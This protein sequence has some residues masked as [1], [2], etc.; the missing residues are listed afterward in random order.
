MTLILLW[1]S[2]IF[3][4]LLGYF[5]RDI[6]VNLQSGKRMKISARRWFAAAPLVRLMSIVCVGLL[7]VTILSTVSW[8]KAG[9]AAEKAETANAIT[10]R[11][12]AASAQATC[13]ALTLWQS[14]RIQTT[15]PD[16]SALP[17]AQRKRTRVFLGSLDDYIAALNHLQDA[18]RVE[19]STKGD[20]Q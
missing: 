15:P 12:E 19:C 10:T 8:I 6:H 13:D 14:L 9:N 4:Y 7:L 11:V 2:W 20:L 18:R 3:F 5:S 16:I 1:L 17:R